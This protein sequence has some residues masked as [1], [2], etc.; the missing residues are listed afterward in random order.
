MREK[1]ELANRPCEK[2]RREL[3]GLH[4]RVRPGFGPWSV[5]NRKSLQIF[6]SVFKFH[7]ILNSK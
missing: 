2:N 7:T 5:G 6:K 4:S 1:N 3:V